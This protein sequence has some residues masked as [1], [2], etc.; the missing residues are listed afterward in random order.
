MRPFVMDR[1]AWS[2]YRSVCHTSEP[3]K[4]DWTDQDAVWVVGFD[5]ESVPR[6]HTRDQSCDGRHHSKNFWLS[7]HGV[8]IRATWGIQLNCQCAAAMRP[9]YQ[10]TLTTCC[11][12]TFI[13]IFLLKLLHPMGILDVGPLAYD[14][15]GPSQPTTGMAS[16]LVQPFLQGS[17]VWQTDRQTEQQP[18]YLFGNNR[19]HLLRSTAMRPKD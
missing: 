4:K 18:R 8:H 10:I 17:L 7:I 3:C 15:W 13:T 12:C 1:V 16:Q 5:G 19:P 14:S 9:S 2:V 11:N 6:Q